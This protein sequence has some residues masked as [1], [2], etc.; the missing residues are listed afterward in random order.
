MA[1]SE[2][3]NF[4]VTFATYYMLSFSV[5]YLFISWN[6]FTFKSPSR[7]YLGM[8]VNEQTQW[9]DTCLLLSRKI[10]LQRNTRAGAGH[11]L[12]R[13]SFIVSRKAVVQGRRNVKNIGGDMPICAGK[14]CWGPNPSLHRVNL[15]AKNWWGPV[16]R[17]G[18]PDY[19]RSK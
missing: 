14:I 17:S 9:N 18:D 13:H 12:V 2:Y 4:K 10:F 6:S 5:V 19:I 8:W 16:W 7:N 15:S 3:M 11:Y 1:F